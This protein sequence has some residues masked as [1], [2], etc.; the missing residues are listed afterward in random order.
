MNERSIALAEIIGPSGAGKS[1]LSALLNRPG[2]GIRAGV[3][4]WK[5]SRPLLAGS[6]LLSLPALVRLRLGDPELSYEEAKQI[7]RL[8]AFGRYLGASRGERDAALLFDEGAVFALSQLRSGRLRYSARLAGW[9]E[10]VLASWA[11]SLDA[12]IWLDAPDE[13]LIA[14]VRSRAKAH[15]MKERPDAEIVEFLARYRS[16]YEMVVERLRRGGRLRVL[17]FDTAAD[18]LEEIAGRLQFLARS[19]AAVE[20]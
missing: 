16:A 15:R 12:V 14:R 1:A 2:S 13:V 17:R 4:I 5:L 11:A 7:V 19:P 20:G 18:S 8:R 6:L 10:K 3:T 9:E